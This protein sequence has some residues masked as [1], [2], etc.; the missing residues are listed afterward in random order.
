MSRSRIDSEFSHQ[1]GIRHLACG[2]MGEAI[3]RTRRLRE[4]MGLMADW[5]SR[6]RL[7]GQWSERRRAA[8]G[9]EP[10][11]LRVEPL[12]GLPVH[13]RP[14]TDDIYML[15]TALRLEWGAPPEELGGSPLRRIADLGTHAGF[16]LARYA[17]EHPDAE[18]LGVEADEGNVALARL[19]TA[20]FGDR[21][22]VSHAAV[23]DHGGE[24]QVE[25]EEHESSGYVVTEPEGAEGADSVRARTVDDLFA[26]RWPNGEC[27]DYVY[28]DVEGAHAKLFHPRAQWARRVRA[29][30]VANHAATPYSE[31]DCARDLEVLG[32][33]TRIIPSEPSGWT[34]GVRDGG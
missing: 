22:R 15:W 11:P 29:I 7:L 28:V 18:L 23:W 26:E 1:S 17:V 33:R 21:C 27:V 6:G 3:T 24:L 9:A 34:I 13:V 16:G 12:G 5:P 8:P 14:G 32:F 31:E 25:H 30:S 19:N 10:V 20:P 4:T 2:R